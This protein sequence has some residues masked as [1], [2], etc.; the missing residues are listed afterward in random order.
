MNDAT[1]V[2]EIEID[3]PVLLSI[4]NGLAHLRL[5]RP[6]DANGMNLELLNAFH[7]ALM[8]CH[9]DSTVRTV[10]ITGEGKNFCAGGDVRVFAEMG[11]ALPDYVR[12]ATAILQN[13]IGAM[14]CMNAPV[15]VAVQGFAA[16]GGGFGLAC[17]ADIVIAAES[18]KFLSGAV[19]VAMAP[20][21]GVSVTLPRLVGFRRAMEIVLTNPTIGAGEAMEM[22][23]VTR[24]VPDAELMNAA[25]EYAREMSEGAPLSLA[26][27]KRLLWTGVGLGVEACM[28]EEART[29]AELSGTADARE[30]L[31]AVIE[32]RKPVFIGK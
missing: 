14:I 10:L 16:G 11:E 15:V 18:A 1:T 9:G 27:A 26:A 2:R 12:Q 32:Q 5:N 20:D 25:V 31:A 19:R 22:G 23:I 13:I 3:G 17:A 21:A 30:G 29:V 24:I 8:V 4:D 28:S 6:D 7:D